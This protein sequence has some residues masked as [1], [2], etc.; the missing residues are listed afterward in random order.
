MVHGGDRGVKN[1]QKSVHM[2]Y[3][4]TLTW[5]SAI[6]E[7]KLIWNQVRITLEFQRQI[8]TP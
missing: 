2:V 8:M 1:V 5:K 7:T 3:G 4:R 6:N